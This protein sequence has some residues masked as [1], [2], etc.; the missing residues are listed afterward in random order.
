MQ[1]IMCVSYMS[2]RKNLVLFKMQSFMK[3]TRSSRLHTKIVF[4]YTLVF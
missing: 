3:Q 1:N 4:D 2:M